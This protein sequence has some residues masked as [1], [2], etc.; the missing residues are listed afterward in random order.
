MLHKNQAKK[1]L[2]EAGRLAMGYFRN[3]EPSL[4]ANN[5]FVTEADLNVQAYLME[6]INENYPDD[7]V[8]AEE[9]D[10]IKKPK[11]GESYFV[12]DPID[13]TSSF[14]AGLPVWG[15]A[16]GVIK[17]K[18]PVA[19]YFY[20]PV[21]DDF[22]YVEPQGAVY[23]NDNITLL[24]P[25]ENIHHESILL[26]ISRT[27]KKLRITSDY[28]GKVR[29]FGSTI[30][31]ICYTATGSVDASLVSDCYIWDL[32]AGL[33]MLIRNGGGAYYLN[34]DPFTLTDGLLSGNKL[35]LPLILGHP[36]KVAYFLQNVTNV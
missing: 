26:T 31:H 7:G 6:K 19:G 4:K 3:V 35:Q 25:T 33:A 32:A 14:V 13:G 27:H 30:A 1:W 22:F 2:K 5:T 18:Q 28:P 17:S 11:D 34:G 29:S 8:L 10:L 16:F 21:T 15:I 20:M 12:I 24:K 23:R 9:G 36:R